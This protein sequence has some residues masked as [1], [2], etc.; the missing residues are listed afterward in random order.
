M[1]GISNY[2]QNF[3][4]PLSCWAALEMCGPPRLAKLAFQG[5]FWWLGIFLELAMASLGISFSMDPGGILVAHHLGNIHIHCNNRKM[6]SGPLVRVAHF[7]IL[8]SSAIACSGHSVVLPSTI[9]FILHLSPINSGT[10]WEWLH[11][12]HLSKLSNPALP[13]NGRHNLNMVL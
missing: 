6:Q 12:L 5:Q 7:L 13:Y 4:C 1:K 11:L 2:F 10:C 8:D 3:Q 9:H